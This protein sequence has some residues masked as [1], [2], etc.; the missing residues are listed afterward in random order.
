MS[1]IGTYRM[2]GVAILAI[3][4][5]NWGFAQDSLLRTNPNFGGSAGVPSTNLVPVPSTSAN[6]LQS[7][8][9]PQTVAPTLP[10]NTQPIAPPAASLG[11]P[12]FDPYQAQPNNNPMSGFFGGAYNPA[13]TAGP[14]GYP[15]TPTPYGAQP[16]SP[17]GA[18]PAPSPYPSPYPTQGASA[19]LGQAGGAYP[20]SVYPGTAPPVLFPGGLNWNVP[21]PNM[22]GWNPSGSMFDAGQGSFQFLQGPRFRQAWVSG[23]NSPESLDILDSD[24]SLALNWP[25][26]LGSFQPLYILPS[27]SLHQWQ[28]PNSSTGA[29]LPSKAYSA[30]IDVGWQSD[31]NLMFGTELGLRTGVF[32]DFET[33]NDKS[34]RIMGQALAKLR[35]T[36]AT[37]LKLGVYYIDRNEVKI[38]PAGGF[39]WQP[40]PHSRWDIFFPLPKLSHYLTTVG[41]QDIWWYLS[42]EYGGGSWTV[43][44]ADGAE[45][46][47]DIN[48]IRV[49]I[50]LEWGRSDLIKSGRR[51]GFFEAGFVF[52]RELDYRY[53]PDDI[54][55]NDTFVLRAGFGY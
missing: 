19:P 47:I 16:A 12:Q 13:P 52:D 6:A 41:T 2:L 34:F 11:P 54:D 15:T 23:N 29:D 7:P 48:D 26:F 18:A 33:F 1:R 24:F 46:S 28:G 32:T 40:T 42:A 49:M 53:S 55:N 44:R 27:F 35:I 3:L 36:P 30:F 20:S 5:I 38:I 4:S 37:T 50:G 31:P 39:L 8:P 14:I 51:I 45:D 25:N 10:P 17:Y 9:Y 21:A 22:Q 43:T